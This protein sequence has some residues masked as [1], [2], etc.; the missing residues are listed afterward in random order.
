MIFLGGVYIYQ[1]H[2]GLAIL[3]VLGSQ[4]ALGATVSCTEK[5]SHSMRPIWALKN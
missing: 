2:A 3:D 5:S 4:W 1:Q